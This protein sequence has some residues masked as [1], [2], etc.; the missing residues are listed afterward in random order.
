MPSATPTL[1]P[2]PRR[3]VFEV[4][5]LQTDTHPKDI[6]VVN[7]DGSG[8]KNLTNSPT[9]DDS[10]VAWAPNGQWL[11]FSSD[12]TGIKQIYLMR[13]DGTEVRQIVQ[14][15]QDAY[16]D[17]W[18]PDSQR[19]YF[20]TFDDAHSD[21]SRAI[22]ALKD[23]EVN[24]DGSG[25]Q[26]ISP[27]KFNSLAPTAISFPEE[28]PIWSPDGTT[29]VFISPC[30]PDCAGWYGLYLKKKGELV[31]R[32]L[33]TTSAIHPNIAPVWS[34]DGTELAYVTNDTDWEAGQ[35]LYV[36]SADGSGETLLW[37]STPAE[38]EI[39]WIQN[40]SVIAWQP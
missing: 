36:M 32:R 9:I 31:S 26:E 39:R 11:G 15:G 28:N 35:K 24:I 18:S 5:F 10:S 33:H 21:Y 1:T 7:A 19:V 30:R 4:A 8:L 25:L 2:T 27:D 14:F 20:W 38:M 17:F 16:F 12:R 34:P 23:Y 22:I 37:D 13:P 3:L 40:L 29:S 6:F